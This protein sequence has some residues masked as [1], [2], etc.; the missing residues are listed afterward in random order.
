MA[1]GE[2]ALLKWTAA[3]WQ[4][5]RANA[6][7]NRLANAVL[8]TALSLNDAFDS[9]E[10]NL[11]A[12][13][14]AVRALNERAICSRAK[15]SQS[16]LGALDEKA[17]EA[18]VNALSD[19]LLYEN[20]KQR[21]F[22]VFADLMERQALGLV[23]TAHPTFSLN[24]AMMD[25]LAALIEGGEAGFEGQD[26]R[27]N[28][29]ITLSDERRMAQ[30]ALGNAQAALH[31]IYDAVLRRAEDVHGAKVWKL[32][33][34]LASVAS[35]V[36]YDLDGRS[37]IDW[38]TSLSFRY[39]SASEQAARYVEDWRNIARGWDTPKAEAV[40]GSLAELSALYR[41]LAEAVPSNANDIEKTRSFSHLS[42]EKNPRRKELVAA[43][44]KD[45]TAL[46]KAA[47]GTGRASALTLFAANLK[48][49]GFGLNHVHF[50]L[51][52]AQLH[53]AVRPA[54]AMETSPDAS[55][56]R[57]RYLSAL[58]G[59]L[60]DVKPVS[61]NYGT[62]MRERTTARRLFMLMAQ[63]LKFVDDTAPIRL[64]IAE[65]DTPFT[66]LTALYYAKLFGIEDKV[67]I[68]P[69]FETDAGLERGARVIGELL[70]DPHYAAY[71]RAQGRLCVQTG[72][73]DAGRYLG[74][75]AAGLA[76]ERFRIKLAQLWPKYQLNRVELVIFDTHGESVG[77]GA[78]PD[79][80][81]ARLDYVHPRRA[82]E[83]MA[84]NG[85]R[86]KQE[87]SLQG[88]DG[89]VWLWS[90]KLALATMSRM[91][92]RALTGPD[93]ANGEDQF[94]IDTDYSLDFFL[95]LKEFQART[96][97]D[98]DYL[99]MLTGFGVNMLFPSGSR[100]TLRQKE[101]GAVTRATHVGQIRAIPHNAILQ[102]MGYMANTLGGVGTAI[103]KDSDGYTLLRDKSAR[104]AQI[105]AMVRHA[106]RYSDLRVFE[107]YLGL[108][109]PE[110]WL[111]YA[112]NETSAKRRE[113]MQ[114][115]SDH[116]ARMSVDVDHS[117][118]I[119]AFW[120][121][122]NDLVGALDNQLPSLLDGHQDDLIIVHV[123][124]LALIQQLFL[125]AA[126]IPRFSSRPDLT[127]EE[128]IEQLLRL[129]VTRS[130]A[131]L[132]EI[133]PIEPDTE[134]NGSFGEPASFVADASRGYA[135]ENQVI[136]DRI[137]R[138]YDLIRR[139]GLAVI[140]HVGAFG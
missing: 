55:S 67:E 112:S 7:D 130:L 132:R 30:R 53:N 81:A 4:E 17:I 86:Y 28:L 37:D 136:F 63:I 34:S 41:D 108:F 21:P 66:V 29:S 20:G 46:L 135:Y 111:H 47:E 59:L 129:D 52:A 104:L 1:N 19:A 85:V 102:Q 123:L 26:F 110:Y 126:R 105:R 51:N 99:P 139:L 43:L 25:R 115:V 72:Y 91:L 64:L 95:T 54:V 137:E 103:A 138:V 50:R 36:G 96:V 38:A 18:E 124:R 113:R 79:G 82:R 88:G 57:R 93:A 125:L 114:R 65:S 101:T 90:E 9:G 117:R 31:R 71:V 109:D 107:G 22:P 106:A 94:Y 89:Y 118:V 84:E 35:W 56:N 27:P 127:V 5:A 60:E 44:H 100:M 13:E 119:R 87:I 24:E 76:I 3:R 121:D 62:L 39:I 134:I 11:D 77:R 133:F 42:V 58:G 23:I 73:S 122:R 74:Q 69:L 2:G 61:V 10:F 68:C 128:V 120:K 32:R 116:L 140:H 80:I 75:I 8:D 48:T 92:K 78:H 131:T 6:K 70:K 14:A 33:P 15:R 40:S 12:A 45:L 97:Y 49:N 98:D 16:Y 83:V